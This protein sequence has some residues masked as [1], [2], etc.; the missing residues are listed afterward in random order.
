MRLPEEDWASLSRRPLCRRYVLGIFD[1]TIVRLRG[2]DGPSDRSVHWAIGCLVD[3]E[4]EPL[5]VWIEAAAGADASVEMVADLMIRGVQRI[6][7]VTGGDVGPVMARLP[8]AFSSTA[9]FSSDDRT[10]SGAPA[11]ARQRLPSAVERAAE[12]FRDD[13]VR[14]IRR[15]RAFDDEAAARDFVSRALQRMERRLDRGRA[16]ARVMPPRPSGAQAVPP[17]F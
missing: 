2:A 14:A 8:E 5:G 3:G 15:H 12:G 13:L 11:S 10:L 17:G 7:H 16:M 6:W 9:V 1:A 4:C